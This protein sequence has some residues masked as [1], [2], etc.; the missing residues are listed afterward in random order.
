MRS[1]PA[2]YEKFL[3]KFDRVSELRGGPV[4]SIRKRQV[5][6]LRGRNVQ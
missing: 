1:V 3:C 4:V 5:Y 6:Q 2:Q